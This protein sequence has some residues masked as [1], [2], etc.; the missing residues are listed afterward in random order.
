MLAQRA[1]PCADGQKKVLKDQY[2]RD[3]QAADA[4]KLGDAFSKRFRFLL[5]T[6]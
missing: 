4:V 3:G 5:N 6:A 2:H 1:G